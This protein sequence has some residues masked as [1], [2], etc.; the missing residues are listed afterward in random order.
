MSNINKRFFWLSIGL[1][2]LHLIG[3]SYYPYF[4]AYFNGLDQAA[5]FATVVTLLRVIFLCWLAYCGYRTLH[6]QQRLTWLYTALF[7][8][9]LICPYFFN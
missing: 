6:D 7:F 9:N 8:V 5:A 2:V 1:T 4:Y 3:A